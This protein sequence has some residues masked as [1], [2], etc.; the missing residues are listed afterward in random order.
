MG[1]DSSMQRISR[2]TPL[3]AIL[4]LIEQRVAAVAPRQMPVA[5]AAGRTLVGDVVVPQLPRQATAL[6][7]GFAVD[8]AALAD[9]SAY[10]P[11]SFANAPPRIDAGEALPSGADAV[12]PVDAVA[13]RGS[14]AEAVMPVVAGEGVLPAGG[15]AMAQTPL[16]RAGQN[17]RALDI[18]AL[19]AA[20]IAEVSVRAPR[21]ALASS[22]PAGSLVG[23]A[24]LDFLSRGVAGAGGLV[25][26][27]PAALEAALADE[28]ND[29]VLVVGGTGSGR[30][31]NAVHILAR[32]G[33]VEA[34]GIAIAPGETAAVGFVGRR[35][36]LLLPGR[37]DAAIA[38][39]LLIGRHL[40][41]KLAGGRAVDRPVP[42]L[43][44]RKITSTIGLTELIPVRC[45]DGLA[46][47]LG[48]GYLSLTALAHSDGFIVVPPDSEGFAEDMKVAVTPWP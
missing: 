20:G 40:M 45:A 17:L 25:T 41:A 1:L 34:H 42:M 9:A 11:V 8:A 10:A 6:R 47:P 5:D 44:K 22:H 24:A 30:R 23:A 15:D 26:S 19:A 43:L 48:C 27:D 12:L 7:D 38:V 29:A 35:P 36:V 32:L 39:W 28:Q 31:D 14:R 21:V 18:A 2:L 4:D 33:R 37:L 3:G 16:R 13:L 46:E